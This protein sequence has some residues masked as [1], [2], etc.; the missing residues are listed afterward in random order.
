MSMTPLGLGRKI[1][2]VKTERDSLTQQLGLKMP[3]GLNFY[4]R[5]DPP[6]Y[7][8][9]RISMIK[10]LQHGRISY[11]LSYS[12]LRLGLQEACVSVITLSRYI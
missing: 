7:S 5:A 12:A 3:P 8:M 9:S 2:G 11:I 10:L 6:A 1:K 4:A